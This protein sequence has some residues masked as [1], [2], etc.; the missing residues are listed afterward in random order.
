M[1]SLTNQLLVSAGQR[2]FGLLCMVETPAAPRIRS[3]A[4]RTARIYAQSPEVMLVLMAF[5]ASG[6]RILISERAMALFTGHGR[7]KA[8]QRKM[9][10]IVIERYFSPIL[11]AMARLTAHAQLLFV[12][13]L[14][15]M[16]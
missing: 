3:V 11:L 9:R 12:R 13:V 4:R 14:F 16:T 10:K 6:G 8:D 15:L 5:L 7:M 2:I 1:A